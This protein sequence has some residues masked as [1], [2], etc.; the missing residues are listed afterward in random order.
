MQ[1]CCRSRTRFLVPARASVAQL[2]TSS[3][4]VALFLGRRSCHSRQANV[5]PVYRVGLGRQNPSSQRS[6]VH[7][8]SAKWTFIGGKSDMKRTH[9]SSSLAS[10]HLLRRG[11]RRDNPSFPAPDHVADGPGSHRRA[12]RS[13][14]C[15]L[16]RERAEPWNN[17]TRSA[18]RSGRV[19]QYLQAYVQKVADA[20]GDSSSRPRSSRAPACTST[21]RRRTARILVSRHAWGRLRRHEPD[22]GT[23]PPSW[24]STTGGKHRRRRRGEM[25]TARD[26]RTRRSR[27]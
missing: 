26:R 6:S 19:L 7:E 2:P 24:R 23:R 27:G 18:W 4:V 21:S 14:D 10:S 8:I 9:R 13:P 25:Q 16:Q 1:R 20:D 22:G 11:P 5:W 15:H 3:S 17:E 12:R